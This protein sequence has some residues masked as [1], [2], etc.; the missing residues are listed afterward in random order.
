MTKIL[1]SQQ[2]GDLAAAD[3]MADFDKFLRLHTA[4]GGREPGDDSQ[5]LRQRGA[6]RGLVRGAW[7]KSSDRYR[8]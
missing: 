8:G 1:V 5:L 7:H 6:I 3:I 2:S 4:D